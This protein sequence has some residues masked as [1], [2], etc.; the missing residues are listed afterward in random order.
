[1]SKRKGGKWIL[2]RRQ[3][4]NIGI[5]KLLKS[6]D[7]LCIELELKES[8]AREAKQNCYSLPNLTF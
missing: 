5:H 8:N 1:M 7:T 6:V 4:F 3:H 2:A